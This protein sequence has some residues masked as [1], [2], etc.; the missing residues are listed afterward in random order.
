MECILYISC[1]HEE[2]GDRIA[3][4]R[5]HLHRCRPTRARIDDSKKKTKIVRVSA[6][7]QSST[8]AGGACRTKMVVGPISQIQCLSHSMS[9][10]FNANVITMAQ[11]TVVGVKIQ[12]DSS[13]LWYPVSPVLILFYHYYR[14]NHFY[15]QFWTYEGYIILAWKHGSPEGSRRATQLEQEKMCS[16]WH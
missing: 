12:D 2:S 3:N 6:C 10:T 11:K 7:V 14:F 4:Q 1:W 15:H 13:L 9:L 5:V 16:M 8:F